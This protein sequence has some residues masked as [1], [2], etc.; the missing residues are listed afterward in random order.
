M[1]RDLRNN[2][3]EKPHFE[4]IAELSDE[5]QRELNPLLP[6]IVSGGKNT[7][8]YYFNHIS[9]LTKYKFNIEPKF[10]GDESSFAEV[11]PQR[12][13]N[14][15]KNNIDAIVYCIF[16][17]ETIQQNSTCL[18]KYREFEQ[19]Y[20]HNSNVII[21][22][23]MP[24]IEYWFLLH[25]KNYIGLIKDNAKVIGHLAIYM[26]QYFDTKIQ[27]KE[28]TYKK[29]DKKFSG[30]LKSH[31]YLEDPS[32]VEKLCA[33]G[34]LDLAIT[35]AEENIRKAIEAND[36]GNQS[37]TYVYRIFKEYNITK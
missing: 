24:C 3:V 1:E 32:W 34:K 2:N 35:R 33:D 7:E 36:L 23:S 31:K 9:K 11:F 25:F 26:K 10:C 18:K 29:V 28:C 16:D 14:I 20:K 22:L 12:I 6:F 13:D 27:D 30:K 19:K 17:Y 8:R 5:G 4:K 21:C 15:L 37:Y